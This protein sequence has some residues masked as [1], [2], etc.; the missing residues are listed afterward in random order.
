MMDK[1]RLIESPIFL[2]LDIAL[3][4]YAAVIYSTICCGSKKT[5][6]KKKTPNEPKKGTEAQAK[7]NVA[8]GQVNQ[9][10]PPPAE[11]PKPPE[12]GGI[13]GTFDPNYQTLAGVGGEVFGEDKQRGGG[14]VPQV[15]VGGAPP[16]PPPPP[17]PLPVGGA[18]PAPAGG[19]PQAPAGGGMAETFDPN[20]QTLAGMGGEIF[21]QDKKVA[22]VGGGGGG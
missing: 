1:M 11:G 2:I 8:V 16:P 6:Q 22:G 14:G 18:P 20:Y 19:G 15:P 7:G 10:V 13:A 17:P 12:Q 4:L 5:P 9:G 21:G 3:V